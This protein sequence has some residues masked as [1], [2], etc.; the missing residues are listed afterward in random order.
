[1]SYRFAI[2]MAAPPLAGVALGYLS[3]GRLGG[4]RTIKVRALW[5][6]WLAAAAQLS[7]YYV[8]AMHGPAALVIVF[9]AVLAWLAVNLPGWPRAIR[10]AGVLI[11]LG[12]ALNGLAIALNGRMPYDAAALPAGSGESSKSETP[13]NV[14]ATEQT[15]LALLGDTM[16]I[17]PLHALI[18]PG[19][20]LIGGGSAALVLLA[21]RRAKR[22]THDREP[23]L[24][25]T[26]PGAVHPGHPGLADLH[27]RRTA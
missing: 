5:L 18:S 6:I 11:V 12:A 8:P 19:D 9:A 24:A 7:Q 16:P 20:I 3:G 10:I 17:A 4:L 1:M 22:S 2:L 14:A 15:R 26:D 21:M 27:D 25:P 13:K 23:D